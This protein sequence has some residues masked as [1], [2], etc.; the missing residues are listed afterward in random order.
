MKYYKREFTAL[1]DNWYFE[2]ELSE[3]TTWV[4]F[5]KDMVSVKQGYYFDKEPGDGYTPITKAE[6][7]DAL[8]TAILHLIETNGIKI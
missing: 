6:F 3:T 4:A 2:V 1:N 8:K 5:E 7:K